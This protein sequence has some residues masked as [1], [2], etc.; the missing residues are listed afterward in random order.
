MSGEAAVLKKSLRLTNLCTVVTL[1][2]SPNES[3]SSTPCVFGISLHVVLLVRPAC[4]MLL[5]DFRGPAKTFQEDQASEG[6]PKHAVFAIKLYH[7]HFA[8][9]CLDSFI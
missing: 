8:S 1:C 5:E 9:C 7:V 4:D 6:T 2:T 3:S